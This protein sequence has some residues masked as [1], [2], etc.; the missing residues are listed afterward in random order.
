MLQARH[1]LIA[2]TC[3]QQFQLV[4]WLLWYKLHLESIRGNER[5]VNIA[6]DIDREVLSQLTLPPYH[7]I[8]KQRVAVSV[9]TALHRHR[10]ARIDHVELTVRYH[11]H[12]ITWNSANVSVFQNEYMQLCEV[13]YVQCTWSKLWQ[14][15]YYCVEILCLALANKRDSRGGDQCLGS[16]VTPTTDSTWEGDH[17]HGRSCALNLRL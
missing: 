2:N 14:F 1:K 13:A 16:S 6:K 7:R 12:E 4:P 8:I 15:Y 3:Y 9:E 10:F 17:H 5:F 11:R